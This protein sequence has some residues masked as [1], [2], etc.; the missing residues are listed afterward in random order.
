MA[1]LTGAP[2]IS[3]PSVAESVEARATAALLACIARYGLSKT[4]LDDVA[5]EAGCSRATLYRYF[6]GKAALVRFTVDTE[7]ARLSAR[8]VAAADD[9]DVLERAVVA[10]VVTAAR[11]LTAQGSLQFLLVHEPE[12]ILGHLA[13]GP[14]DRL[15]VRVGDALAPAFA[16]WLDDAAARRAGDWV[17]RVLRSYVLMPEPSV[18]LTDSTAARAFLGELVV[19]GLVPAPSVSTVGSS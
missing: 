14:G 11:D 15:L 8:A 4:T 17:A 9:E 12:S 19:P 3:P 18:D 5:R 2:S 10:L 16:R 6:D 13:F 1:V 7:L